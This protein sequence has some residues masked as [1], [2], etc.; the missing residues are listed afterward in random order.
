[1]K[2]SV[3]ATPQA[4]PSQFDRA[5]QEMERVGQISAAFTELMIAYHFLTTNEGW[6]T[7]QEI[8]IGIELLGDMLHERHNKALTQL[9]QAHGADLAAKGGAQ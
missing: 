8:S 4:A 3:K 5:W 9:S 6:G 2:T 1:M 7:T